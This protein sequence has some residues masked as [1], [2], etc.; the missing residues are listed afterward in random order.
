MP[1][2]QAQLPSHEDAAPLPYSL[3]D[4]AEINLA[5]TSRPMAY[6]FGSSDTDNGY[7]S[8]EYHDSDVSPSPLPSTRHKHA[9]NFLQRIEEH[10]SDELDLS[11]SP[12][13]LPSLDSSVSIHGLPFSARSYDYSSAFNNLGVNASMEFTGIAPE[14]VQKYISEQSGETNKW[15]CL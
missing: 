5:P 13:I 1:Q 10:P 4:M 6:G 9:Q 12:P 2:K 11:Y 15:T 8:L 7:E 14:E 3:T